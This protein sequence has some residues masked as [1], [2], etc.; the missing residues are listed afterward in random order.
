MADYVCVRESNVAPADG[1]TLDQA[2]M[3]EFLAIGAHAVRR[4]S[5]GSGDRVLVVGA[6]PIGLGC[7]IFAKL[8]GAAVTALDVRQ[9]R[10]DFCRK[11][12]SVDHAVVAGADTLATLSELT[13]GDLFDVV[14]DATGAASA[15]AAGFDYVAHGGTYVL[16]SVVRDTISFS[17]PKFHARE[18][19][20]LASRN[21]TREDFDTVFK[22]MRKGL[23]P[24]EALVTHRAS[25]A[26]S[27]A[28]FPEWIK[29][30]TGV[31]K[32]LIEI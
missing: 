29:P 25:L 27:P 7:V 2:A 14:V 13:N 17:D 26:E 18:I 23:L 12:L 24:T 9:D 22:M 10:L 31:I 19:S 16:V 30:E 3:I 5:P 4:A 1:V 32:A 28:R 20:L 6:G 8:R 11:V 15:M 21:A